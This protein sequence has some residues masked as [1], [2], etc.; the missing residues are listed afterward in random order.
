MGA[1][2]AV[3]YLMVM[4]MAAMYVTSTG[5]EKMDTLQTRQCM[6]E[7]VQ[8]H[9][10]VKHKWHSRLWSERT[11]L[12]VKAENSFRQI[13]KIKTKNNENQRGDKSQTRK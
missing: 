3:S 4:V 9:K 12:Q 1:A 2:Q 13:T 5:R 7:K 8:C 11:N 10:W 6:V